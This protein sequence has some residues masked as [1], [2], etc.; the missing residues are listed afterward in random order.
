MTVS[1][2]IEKLK[3]FPQN[4]HVYILVDDTDPIMAGSVYKTTEEFSEI[5][6]IIID[7]DE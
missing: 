1:E 2:L 5:E 7:E 6:F 4:L 3:K